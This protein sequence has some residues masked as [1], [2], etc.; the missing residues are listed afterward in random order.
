MNQEMSMIFSLMIIF[1]QAFYLTEEVCICY[2]VRVL[3]PWGQ[4]PRMIGKTIFVHQKTALYLMT[5]FTSC[6]SMDCFAVPQMKT[7]QKFLILIFVQR[8]SAPKVKNY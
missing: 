1:P 6:L 8:Q 3:V 5:R 2:L 7:V 4:V